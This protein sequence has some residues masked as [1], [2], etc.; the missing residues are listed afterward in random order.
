M[1]NKRVSALVLL[2]L[3]SAF[4]TVD[5]KLL[6]PGCLLTLEF[7]VLPYPFSL[8]TYLTVHKLFTS[9]PMHPLPLLSTRVCLKALCLALYFLAFILLLCLLP[10][11]SLYTTPMSCRALLYHSTFTLMTLNFTFPSLLQI[12]LHPL[13]TCPRPLTLSTNGFLLIIC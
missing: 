13:L 7:L 1:E 11:Y 10:L 12:P 6:H 9:A 4:D 3:S 8:R 2:D 5:H